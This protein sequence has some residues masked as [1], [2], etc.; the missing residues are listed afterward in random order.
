MIFNQRTLRDLEYEKIKDQI[1]QFASSELGRAFIDK[2]KPSTNLDWIENELKRVDEIKWAIETEGFALDLIKDLNPILEKSKK[3]TSLPPED[4]LTILEALRNGRKVK[5]ELFGLGE[6]CPKLLEIAKGIEVFTELEGR[7]RST[8]NEKGE[9]RDTASPALKKLIAEK[10]GIEE[11]VREKLHSFFDLSKYAHLIQEKVITRRSSRLVIPIKKNFVNDIDCVVHGNSS[12]GQTLYVEPT[13]VVEENNKIREL[14]SEI[15]NEKIRILKAL[16]SKVG[17]RKEAIQ[18]SQRRLALLD[19]L[20]ARGRY[21]I[22]RNCSAPQINTEGHVH[23]I[24]GRHPL[25]SSDKVVPIEISFGDKF[26]G[27]LI[28][29]PNTGGK[30]VSL[31][32]VGLFTLMVQSG[33]QIPASPDSK[34]CVFQKVRSDIGDEQSIEQ[35][36]STFSSH[37]ENIVQI[38]EEVSEGTLVLLDELGAGTD[39]QEGAGLGIAILGFLLEAKAKLF[40]STH[41]SAL[42]K[43]AYQHPQLK[44]CSVDFDTQTLSPTYHILEGVPG[45][46]NAYII[47]DKLGLPGD[48]LAQAKKMLSDGE[49]KAEDIIRDLQAQRREVIQKEKKLKQ[50]L[51]EADEKEKRYQKLLGELEEKKEKALSGELKS[52]DGY[53][54][55]AKKRIEKLLAQ[56]RKDSREEKIKASLSQLM[57][58]EEKL[59]GGKSKLERRRKTVTLEIKDLKVGDEVLV[60]DIGKVG[61]VEGTED[62]ENIEV[63]MGGVK[64]SVKISDLGPAPQKGAKASDVERPSPQVSVSSTSTPPL[65][66]SVRGLTVEEAIRKVDKYLDK[67]LLNDVKK[68]RII[69]GKGAGTLRREIR[70]HLADQPFIQDYYSPPPYQGG[71]GVTELT[72]G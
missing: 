11:E 68:A 8:V 10:R 23:L 7:I 4:L 46:S 70:K 42:K 25:L 1:K 58:I 3:S 34:L 37:M 27:A 56:A 57:D 62:G 6:E 60:K 50:K 55:E 24:D 20:Y 63:K 61:V 66:L 28:T 48:I 21:A 14:A 47:A 13:S 17:A 33:I 15:R 69:H 29:G 64:L 26:Q 35:S 19:S 32:T 54:K 49:V 40:V 12:T 38:I 72:L 52:L 31:K 71:D 18:E 16:T 43:F 22:K 39:P 67:L 36:L 45:A 53:L 65:E 44:S 9:I 51:Q 30:T 59:A 2:L 5:E 41:S